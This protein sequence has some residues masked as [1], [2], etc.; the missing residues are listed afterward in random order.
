MTPISVNAK[1][2]QLIAEKQFTTAEEIT[3]AVDV[4]IMAK[5]ADMF[6]HS[7]GKKLGSGAVSVTTRFYNDFLGVY[8]KVAISLENSDEYAI[9]FCN[10]IDQDGMEG[11]ELSFEFHK[12][13]RRYRAILYRIVYANG[14]TSRNRA[15]VMG[16]D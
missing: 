10:V 1:I 16:L 13:S 14:I 11:V 4:G 3:Q 6:L 8:S 7:I 15:F 2:I 12:E 9:R 5:T